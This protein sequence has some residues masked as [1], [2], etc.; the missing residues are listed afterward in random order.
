M[1]TVNR[2]EQTWLRPE[3][4]HREGVIEFLPLMQG[5]SGQPD[6][7]VMNIARFEEYFTPRHRHNYDQIRFCF[8]APFPYARDKV[9]PAGWVGYFPEGTAYGPQDVR[10]ELET[11]PEVLTWQFGGASGQGFVSAGSL[12][13]AYETLAKE[14]R[15]ERGYFV[16][17]LPDGS[18]H[19]QDGYEAAWAAATGHELAYPPARFAEPVLMDPAAFPWRATQESGVERKHLATFEPQ[20][21]LWFTRSVGGSVQVPAPHRAVQHAYVLHGEI[22]V[23]GKTLGEGTAVEFSAGESQP[24]TA[25]PIGAELFWVALPVLVASNAA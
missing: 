23:D 10:C 12:R 15:F 7:Y 20:L 1:R 24:I 8:K 18:E 13:D 14:G 4:H 3:G 22:V 11:G 17:S 25:G 16:R 2:F 6:H 5:V 19:K 21:S 9:I